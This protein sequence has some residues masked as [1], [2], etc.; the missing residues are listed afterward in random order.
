MVLYELGGR[1]NEALKKFH[2]GG[3]GEEKAVDECLKNISSALLEANV[4]VAY[5][6]Q[7]RTSVKKSYLE[8]EQR[9][10]VLENPKRLLQKAVVEQLVR[11]LTPE[12]KPYVP[13]KSQAN[14]I[15]FVGLQG[16]GK[17]TTCA[18][19]ALHYLKKGWK[20]AIVAADTFR[21]GAFDQVKQ[22]CTK[23]QVPFYGSHTET[24]S[25][26]IAQEGV[27]IFKR[28]KRNYIIVDTS[29][30]HQQ[31]QAL[32]DEMTEVV[33][34]VK[35]DEIVYVMDSHIGQACYNQAKAFN[36]AVNIAS[37][38]VTKLDGHAKGGGALSAVA[39]TNSP[40]LFIGTGE[41]F[42]QIEPF[43]PQSFV[44]R[45]LGLG[46]L[47]G[48]VST[49]RDLVP[50]GSQE[51]IKEKLIKGQFT[52]ADMRD[53]LQNFQKMGSMTNL[54]S[55][56]PGLGANLMPEGQE[57]EGTQR[58][59]RFLY[60]FDS[61]TPN[62]INC[63]KPIDESRINRLARG[64]G[65]D[66][67]EVKMLLEQHKEFQSMVSKFGKMAKRGGVPQGAAM[68]KMMKNPNQMMQHL[69]KGVPPQI[70]KQMG[71]SKNMMKMFQE[72][73]D[74]PDMKEMMEQMAHQQGGGHRGGRRGRK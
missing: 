58:I 38:I 22:N 2:G 47:S 49:M 48:L 9:G 13:K 37:V 63:V 56:I 46:D 26:K 10:S 17:T 54:M 55:M 44:K 30:R 71:G 74:S 12:R 6:A 24:S 59:K 64:S 62:E 40:I 57:Q 1:I 28:E 7:L 25:A 53:Q 27:E 33:A 50:E 21:A 66:I 61:M 36:D 45:I 19:V 39:A 68:Q 20:P 23:I 18:K 69:N 8:S 31:E 72:M 3:E 52:L 4:N 67:W 65:T 15:L 32:F 14:V 29:G 11:L 70:L 73:Q 5:V 41:A 35:P 51:A 16:A 42:E 43:N 60:V 34:A